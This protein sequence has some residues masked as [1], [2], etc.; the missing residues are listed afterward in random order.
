M[1]ILSIKTNGLKGTHFLSCSGLTNDNQTTL[2]LFALI[3]V[4]YSKGNGASLEAALATIHDSMTHQTPQPSNGTSGNTHDLV[5]R[6]NDPASSSL[7]EGLPGE[8]I[9]IRFLSA[10]STRPQWRQ[11][12]SITNEYGQT[13]AHLAVA[14]GYAQLL[15]HLIHWG[16]DL[17]VADIT[18]ATALHL[19]Y[20]FHQSHCAALLIQSGARVFVLDDLGRP[21]SAQYRS[22]LSVKSSCLSSR[23]CENFEPEEMMEEKRSIDNGLFVER[24]INAQMGH[25]TNNKIDIAC[26][27]CCGESFYLLILSSSLVRG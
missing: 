16:I 26:N 2:S 10:C 17:H 1:R 24:W 27:H 23:N 11:S 13:L 6:S 9:S 21:P 3:R 25:K 18:G 4:A 5:S 12:I 7:L 19:A 20:V 8:E 15:Q 22:N 14:L